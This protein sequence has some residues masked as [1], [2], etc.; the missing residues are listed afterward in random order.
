MYQSTV[1]YLVAGVGL[2]PHD[3]R[4]MRGIEKLRVIIRCLIWRFWA[5]SGGL[6]LFWFF[7]GKVNWGQIGVIAGEGE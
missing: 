6:G 1:P 3:L 7:V 2:E 4:V 5:V